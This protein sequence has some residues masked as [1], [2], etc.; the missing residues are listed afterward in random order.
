MSSDGTLATFPG[1]VQPYLTLVSTPRSNHDEIDLVL[2]TLEVRPRSNLSA[3]TYERK[4]A[5][6][7]GGTPA[8]WIEVLEA[9]DEVF[10][11]NSL[12]SAEDQVNVVR[13]VLCGDLI[14]AFVSSLQEQCESP[15][16]PG[17]LVALSVEIVN[18]ALKEVSQDEPV[19]MGIRK[20]VAAVTKMNSKLVRLPRATEADFFS[21]AVLVELL[22]FS[23][24]YAWRISFDSAG[25][26]P[27]EHGKACLITK[28]EQ[29]DHA[30][31][32]AK[33]APASSKPKA[34]SAVQG[35]SKHAKAGQSF[36][37][38]KKGTFASGF[39]YHF[40]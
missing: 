23:L 40:Q 19:D 28:G 3:P 31:A 30:M 20:L 35:K 27:T 10:A 18:S 16:N 13:T 37:K 1:G 24:P 39:W 9:L 8:G 26:I 5:R 7:A 22:E 33:A 4:V 17:Q 25:F 15:G 12:V 36:H 14:M 11:Q 21:S 6:F 29:D 2:F 38:G 32:T 34:H